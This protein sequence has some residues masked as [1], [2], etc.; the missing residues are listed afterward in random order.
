MITG[1]KM[2]RTAVILLGAGLL[3]GCGAAQPSARAV[4]A[5]ASRIEFGS[6][7]YLCA[8]T[9][10]A[11]KQHQVD[12]EQVVNGCLSRNRQSLRTFF[13]LSKNAGFDGAAAEGH[14]AVS[15]ILL[16]SLGDQFFGEC[17]AGEPVPIRNAVRDHLLYDLG[18]G[19]TE[20][21]LAEI[22]KQYPRTFPGDWTTDNPVEATQP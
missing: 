18:Y 13:W 19:A 4:L 21:T 11:A 1:G 9:L 16:R 7:G 15:G 22:K 2:G 6:P 8:D 5:E 12:Y 17:L 3:A 20:L 14:A 10:A